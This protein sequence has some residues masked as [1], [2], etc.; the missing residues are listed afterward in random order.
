MKVLVTG[1]CGFIGSHLVDE[2]VDKGY[3]P[4][5][6]DDLSADN[7]EFFFNEGAEYFHFD[8]CKTEQLIE[9]SKKCEY[10]FHLAAE[11]RLGLAI[12]NPNKA[13]D[14]NIK[15]T[16]SILEAAKVNKFKGIVFSSTSSVYG[17]NT[18]FPIKETEIEDCLNAYS[19]TKYCAEKF[20][21]NYRDMYGVPSVI[22]RYF[23]VFGERAPNKGQYALVTGI[24]LNQL[25]NNQ[26]LTVTGDGKQE[27]D[28]V[29]VKDVVL[30]NIACIETYND[31][32]WNAEVFNVGSGKTVSIIEL[33][34]TLTTEKNIKYIP[35]RLG[36]AEN[37]LSDISKILKY[38]GWNP[39]V[40]II[41]WVKHYSRR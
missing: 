27:R 10:A 1:G 18:N 33:A 7:E 3:K 34:K 14:V 26:P 19:A 39:K 35:K 37:N 22:L 30:A 17:M 12:L 8:V 24:F 38:L 16:I 41:D 28:F 6:V 11:S 40:N 2:L 36:E 23:N 29:Y 20:F 32:I 31:G 4:I 9:I 25:E 21:K 13:V 5:V 15:G